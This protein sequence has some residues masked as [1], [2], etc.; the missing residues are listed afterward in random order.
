[1]CSQ[2]RL[3][4]SDDLRS[5]EER[6]PKQEAAISGTDNPRQIFR[7]RT[8]EISVWRGTASTAPVV[9]LV[10]SECDRPSRFRWHPCLLPRF[11]RRQPSLEWH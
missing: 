2:G 3:R 7:A 8:S 4:F 6:G 11:T 5:S 1:M 10:H 9:E